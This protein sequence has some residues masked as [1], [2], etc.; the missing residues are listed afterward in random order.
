MTPVLRLGLLGHNVPYTRSPQIFE[1]IFSQ[2]GISGSFEVF[3]VPPEALAKWFRTEL[4]TGLRGLAV[5]IPHKQAVVDYLDKIGNVAEALGAV[6]SISVSNR[7]L[8]GHNTD[9]HGF[10]TALR[11]CSVD[12]SGGSAVILGSGGAARAALYSLY[13]DFRVTRFIVIGRSH[14]NLLDFSA[15]FQRRLPNLVLEYRVGFETVG[16][17][18]SVNVASIIVNCTP[19]GGWNYADVSP[20]PEDFSFTPRM[21]YC[22][23]N[24]NTDNKLVTRARRAGAVACDG[25][26]MLVVQAVRSFELWAGR[27]VAWQ[28][29]Y[30]MVFGRPSL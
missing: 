17:L 3:D 13:S 26:I 25:A 10:S 20:F 16:R 15:A 5:T 28:P 11:Q 30:E 7:M 29:I 8:E 14:S 21:I 18:E 27:T 4:P 2:T 9:V 6:N 19:L 1:A 22:D 23:V 24:Y 12:L